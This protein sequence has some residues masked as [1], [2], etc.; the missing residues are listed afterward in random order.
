MAGA[1]AGG[2]WRTDPA[3]VEGVLDGVR[4]LRFRP[5]GPARGVVLHLH[6]GGFRQGCPEM[7]GPYAAALAERCGV[8][9]VCP[10]YRLAPEHPFPAGLNDAA[11]VYRALRREGGAPLIV[12]GDSAGGGLAASLTALVTSERD[13]PAALILL[14]AWLDL[15]VSAES[16][17]ANA[18]TD[19]LFSRESGEAAAELYLQGHTPEDP[20]ASPLLAALE[21]FPPT[22]VNFGEGEVLADDSRAFHAALQAAGVTAELHPVPGMD[23]VAVTRGP[24]LVGAPETFAT[25]AAF[26]GRVINA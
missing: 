7:I 11:K 21:G 22:L 2:T 6:G 20:L 17:R 9:V 18:A 5:A 13:A 19:P 26:V 25:V 10:A 16:Y 14:S 15:T 23:H 24:T 12:S 3:P 4:V 1:I 8:E